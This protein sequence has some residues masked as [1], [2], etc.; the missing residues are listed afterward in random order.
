MEGCEVVGGQEERVGEG[1]AVYEEGG[2]EGEVSVQFAGWGWGF[3]GMG[4][5][6]GEGGVEACWGEEGGFE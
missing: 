6:Y 3:E 2:G 1:V 5:F 4:G